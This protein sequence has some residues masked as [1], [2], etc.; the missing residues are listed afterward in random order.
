MSKIVPNNRPE[1]SNHLFEFPYTKR[2]V[3]NV[4][5]LNKLFKTLSAFTEFGEVELRMVGRHP[6]RKMLSEKYGIKNYRASIPIKYAKN[7]IVYAF[8][9]PEETSGFPAHLL[10]GHASGDTIIKLIKVLEKA[11]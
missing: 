9:R 11:K 10:P 1:K 6:N 3:N 4:R 7:V 2:M 8:T 5:T